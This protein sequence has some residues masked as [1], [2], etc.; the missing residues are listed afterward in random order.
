[1]WSYAIQSAVFALLAFAPGMASFILVSVLMGITLRAAYTVCAAAS[2]DYVPVQFSAAAFALM[3]VGASLGSTISPT[4]GGVVA[5]HIDMKWSFGMGLAGTLAGVVGGLYL[6][7]RKPVSEQPQ[8]L[9]A[10]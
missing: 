3:S 4:V 10:D 7:T 1:M 5:D 9:P 6:Q 2:G 8:P